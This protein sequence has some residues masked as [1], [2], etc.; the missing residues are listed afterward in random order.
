MNN[1]TELSARHFVNILKQ[2]LGEITLDQ[3]KES[4]EQLGTWT[5]GSMLQPK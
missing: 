2:E 4:T 3:I 5:S 1:N